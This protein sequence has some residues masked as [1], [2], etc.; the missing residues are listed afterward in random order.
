M[1]QDSR[2]DAQRVASRIAR[3]VYFEQFNGP[4]LDWQLDQF[5]PYLGQR[6]L[7]IGCGIGS[8]IARLGPGPGPGP[9]ELIHGVDVE[10]DVL[11]HAAERFRDRPECRF[12]C[13]DLFAAAAAAAAEPPPDSI[14]LAAWDTILC[15][16]VLEHVADDAAALQRM[17][18]LVSPG[19]HLALLVPAHPSLYGDYDRLDGH[20]RRYTRSGLASLVQ[21]A[22]WR[23]VGLKH[24]N[25]LGAVGWWWQYRLLK[26]TIHGR[27]AFRGMN[28]VLP[29]AKLLERL[30]APPF[31][32][33]LAAVLR[34]DLD[35]GN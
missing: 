5:R 18:S 15:I 9:R 25:A 31:G 26:R 33:S 22:G 32:L 1:I 28:L 8:L 29:V 24:F 6:I 7:E 13:V 21:Q 30:L 12:D 16:N 3:Y 19:G 2:D 23:I 17:W 27:R 34:R 35:R 11:R 10:A 14:R 20:Y 4:Y